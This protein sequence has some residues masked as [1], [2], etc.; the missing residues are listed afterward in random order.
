LS[1]TRLHP[2]HLEWEGLINARD[3]GGLT[4]AGGVVREGALVRSD[5]LN[6]L[7]PNGVEALIEHGVRTVIDV[8]SAN[9]ISHA[10]ERYPL[11]EHDLVEYRNLPFRAP[12]DEAAAAAVRAAWDGAQSREEFNRADLD[13]HRAGITAIVSAIADAPPG[14]VLVHCHA[15]KDRT[16]IVVAL[17][18]A[19]VGVSDDE[20]A[21]DYALSELAME[22]IMVEWLAH[23]GAPESEHERHW[24][25]AMP[26][27]EAML[28]TLAYLRERYGGAER[29]LLDAGMT[30]DQ[31]A[32][33]R[34]RL[35]D[36]K[37]GAA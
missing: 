22:Q 23:I 1:E 19:V 25:L 26:S 7:T 35:V 31:M 18:L 14:G 36:A 24:A 28:D 21:Q 32:R 9:E 6:D 37:E 30:Q 3:S 13:F 2:R 16:G 5:V 11:R 4:A 34:A 17:A 27:R 10:W 15:G 29:Y 8:R 20:I 12:R 33:L